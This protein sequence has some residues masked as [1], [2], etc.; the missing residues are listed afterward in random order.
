MNDPKYKVI[1][2]KE[3]VKF[4]KGQ[5]P[6]AVR[7][8]ASVIDYVAGGDMNTEFLRNLEIQIFGS[9]KLNLWELPIDY[10]HFGIRENKH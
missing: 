8:I 4:L 6:K 3:V 7:K 10:S 5:N 2:S 9:S 1:L